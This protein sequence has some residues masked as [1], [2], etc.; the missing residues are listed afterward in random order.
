MIIKIKAQ[1]MTTS[2]RKIHQDVLL[3]N[4][5]NKEKKVKEKEIYKKVPKQ[6]SKTNKKKTKK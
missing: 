4:K 3:C 1:F 5:G 6:H 2:R